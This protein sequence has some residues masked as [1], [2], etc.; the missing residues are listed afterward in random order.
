MIKTLLLDLDGTLFDDKAAMAEATKAFFL[1]H[2]KALNGETFDVFFQ[3]W[4]SIA[5]KCWARFLSGELSFEGQ[6]RERVREVLGQEVSDAEADE[7]FGPHHDAYENT[8]GCY[9]DVTEF[10]QR[11]KNLRKIT[12]TNGQRDQQRLKMKKTGLLADIPDLVTPE[13]AGVS[14]PDVGIFNYALRAL[15]AKPEEAMMI[16]D[17]HECDIAP[18]KKLGMRTLWVRRP[19]I[20]LADVEL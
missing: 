7:A 11:T 13:D 15:G 17:D 10:L 18:A 9:A 12:V 6:R 19:E 8:W 1:A 14:K 2:E 4:C 20:G 5:D 16:G 3:R